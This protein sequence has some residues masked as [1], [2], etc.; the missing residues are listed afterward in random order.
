MVKEKKIVLCFSYCKSMRHDDP[1]PPP[2]WL[3]WT[4]WDMIGRI[5]VGYHQTLLHVH[6]K[7]QTLGL[8]VSDKEIILHFPIVSL[9]GMMTPRVWPI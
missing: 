6:T 5:Y 9:L 4:P 7:I 2:V 3:I 1:P 8:V